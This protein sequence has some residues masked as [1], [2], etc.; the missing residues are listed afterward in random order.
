MRY[1]NHYGLKGAFVWEVDTDNFMGMYGKLRY[2]IL[3]AIR[4]ALVGGQGLETH[5]ILGSANENMG[6]S[7]QARLDENLPI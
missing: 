4:D 2:T 7:P 1:A 5:E 3:A 6:C